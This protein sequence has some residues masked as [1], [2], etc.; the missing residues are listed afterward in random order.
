MTHSE[1]QV[2]NKYWTMIANI[3]Y[4]VEVVYKHSELGHKFRRIGV[5]KVISPT[6][7]YS[8]HAEELFESREDLKNHVFPEENN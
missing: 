8:R 7:I 3:P 4:E 5:V 2:E 6:N 1:V